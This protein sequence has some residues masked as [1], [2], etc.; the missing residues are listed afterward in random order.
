[1]WHRAPSFNYG[2]GHHR[3]TGLSLLGRC[4]FAVSLLALVSSA[5]VGVPAVGAAPRSR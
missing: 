1:M 4:G 2:V 3:R 5:L